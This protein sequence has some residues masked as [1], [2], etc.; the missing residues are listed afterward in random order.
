[1]RLVFR[2]DIRKEDVLTEEELKEAL[3]IGK[4]Q[5]FI[6]EEEQDMIHSILEFSEVRASEIMTPR[7]DVKAIDAEDNLK[8][9]ENH[10]KEIRHSYVPVYKESIDN[11]MGIVRTK[12]YF[13]K[14]SKKIQDVVR[15]PIFV[16]ETKLISDLLKE[17]V[18]QREKMALVMDEYGGLSGLVTLEDIQE[19]IFG[20]IY[21]EYEVPF[22][23]IKKIN[24]HEFLVNPR[25]PIKDLNYELNL[26]IPEEE[27][28]LSGFLLNLTKYF[29]KQG[30]ELSFGELKFTIEKA[31]RK[32]IL[33]IKLNIK[34]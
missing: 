9:I 11:L 18:P 13:L 5:S 31:T 10:L 7:V 12:D 17:M 22:E 24:K 26:N 3:E 32:K 28:N 14:K 23:S 6:D 2:R 8:E 1:M 30:E 16:P 27:D 25:I 29:P 34:K 4:A 15:Q 33:L 21:D 20:E 19:E